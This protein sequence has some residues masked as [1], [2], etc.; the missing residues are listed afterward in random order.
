MSEH[1]LDVQYRQGQIV[2]KSIVEG[3]PGIEYRVVESR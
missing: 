1:I 3:E 2:E